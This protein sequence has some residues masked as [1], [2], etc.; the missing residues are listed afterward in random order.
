MKFDLEKNDDLTGSLK[1]TILKSDYQDRVEKQIKEVRKTINLPGFRK[2]NVPVSLIKKQYGTGIQVEE[3]NKL[4]QESING[5][6]QEQ[7]LTLLGQ[8]IPKEQ[9]DIDWSS[10]ELVFDFDLGMA[11]EV[12]LSIDPKKDILP[13]R[14]VEVT[15]DLLNDEIDSLR[16]RHGQVDQVEEIGEA[17]F[18]RGVYIDPSQGE[19]AHSHSAGFRLDDEALSKLKTKLVG[20]KKDDK[21]MISIKDDFEDSTKA[22]AVLGIEEAH[23]G[24]HSNDVEFTVEGIV[25]VTPTAM[26]K[27]DLFSK[28]HPD[29]ETEE[30][31]REKVKEQ[32]G[33]SFSGDSERM[34]QNKL[35]E[36]LLDKM[37]L[38][39]PE[40]FL[41][42]WMVVASE[43]DEPMT[44]EKVEKEY[45]AMARGIQWQLIETA[46][47]Q[48]EEIKVEKEDLE[49]SAKDMVREQ[50]AAYG[51]QVMDDALVTSIA[52][53]YLNDGERI[54]KLYERAM[55]SKVL[56]VL[57]A[58]FGRETELVSVDD[59]YSQQ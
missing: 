24:E 40:G 44:D 1:I 17:D 54:Q 11:P 49:N 29:V 43:G 36:Y 38:P 25:R 3:V 6:I 30:E 53:N 10:E 18:V 47:A 23:L 39:L 52:Q 21:V 56:A 55:Q 12:K 58:K 4:L 33:N 34:F 26:T 16:R 32:L 8:P 37:T 57:S 19:N 7:Q 2:G 28:V 51:Q 22:A 20:G 5:Y 42:K 27:E 46:V 13:F 31:F 15:E 41:K 9:A 14:Q 35:I 50:M 45:P 59:F 48:Q